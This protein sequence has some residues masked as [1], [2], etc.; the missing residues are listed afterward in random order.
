MP[1]PFKNLPNQIRVPLFYAEVN[2]SRANT[3]QQP[4]RSWL[5]GQMFTAGAN[6]GAAT[7]SV[8]VICGGVAQAAQL[9]GSGSM[10]HLMAI[11][12]FLNDPFGEVWLLPL[13]DAGGST[14]ATGSLAFTH[15]ATANGTLSL[16]IAGM[17]V[18]LPVLT[19]QT[20]NNLAT[21]LAAAVNAV[22]NLP[23][24][25]AVDG[26]NAF[27]VNFTALNA[28]PGGN[29]IDLRLNY[30]GVR[31]GEST[32]A[33]LTTTFTA[34]SGGATPP[35]LTT[36]LANAGDKAYDFIVL[37]YTDS[38]SLNGLQAFLNDSTGRWSWQSRIY[39]HVFAAYRGTYGA[40]TTFGS[41]R[42]DQHASI[43]G[44]YDSP[45]PSWVWAAAVAGAAAVS[46]R[47]FAPQ[48]LQTLAIAGVLA[49]PLASRFPL[50]ERNTLLYDGISTFTVADDGTVA[51]ERLITTYQFNPYGQPDNSYLPVER[52]FQLM[53]VLRFLQIRIT[54]KFG[55]MALA[56]DGT[57]FAAGLPIVT[58]SILRADQIAAYGEL[59]FAGQVQNA[60]EF[61]EGLIV[62]RNFQNGI[63]DVNR[64]DVLWDGILTNQLN[65]FALL[66][67]FSA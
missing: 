35:S 15:V 9:A 45:T 18:T 13:A 59:E 57:R 62:Q 56:D 51:I 8:P 61:A 49:P 43:M 52:M 34:M 19:T 47:N 53:F 36:G 27:Q 4:Q 65:I 25:A 38:T 54:S 21:A 5:I 37:P 6:A 11:A 7:P 33:G 12:Y 1:L 55:R 44:F 16:Y 29:D 50:P 40:L 17:L 28:G 2:N 46:L 23:V 24:S 63:G 14:A 10:L 30:G 3:A 22:P 31:N 67:M 64:I 41:G 39:G 66:A 48:P 32:P 26:T 20:V 58:P 60:E 42:N